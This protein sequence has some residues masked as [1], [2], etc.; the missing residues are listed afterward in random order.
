MATNQ[1]LIRKKA[2]QHLNDILIDPLD[3]LIE[4]P[5]DRSIITVEGWVGRRCS[6]AFRK[7]W[8]KEKEQ[9]KPCDSDFIRRCIISKNIKG[10]DLEV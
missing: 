1:A 6:S 5:V 4:S 10:F 7:K 3:A 8:D 2:E 9:L